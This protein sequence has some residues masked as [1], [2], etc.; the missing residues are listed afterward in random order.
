M[1]TET[2]HKELLRDML[3]RAIHEGDVELATAALEAGEKASGKRFFD[4]DRSNAFMALAIKCNQPEIIRLLRDRGGFKVDF[5]EHIVLIVRENKIDLLSVCLEK[6]LDVISAIDKDPWGCQFTELENIEAFKVA[7]AKSKNPLLFLNQCNQNWDSPI[8]IAAKNNSFEFFSKMIE[9]GAIPNHR[10]A[11]STINHREE[12]SAQAGSQT[13]LEA[14][15][16]SGYN[17]NEKMRGGFSLLHL[18]AE[19]GCTRLCEILIDH[20][21]N[22]EARCA[23][24]ATPILWGAQWPK[25]ASLLIDKGANL[26]ATTDKG[27]NILFMCIE[28]GAN[29]CR[30]AEICEIVG[31]DSPLFEAKDNFKNTLLHIIPSL[32]NENP[33][34]FSRLLDRLIPSQIN[35]CN[36]FGNTPLVSSFESTSFRALEIFLSRGADIERT[37]SA[38]M[39]PLIIAAKE[40]N[41][42]ACKI[43][44]TA[45]ANKDAQDIGGRT[46]MDWAIDGHHVQIFSV[47]ASFSAKTNETDLRFI[48]ENVKT[49][50]FIKDT[51]LVSAMRTEDIEFLKAHLQRNP[52]QSAADIKSGHSHLNR[53][54]MKQEMKAFFNSWIAQKSIN[55]ILKNANTMDPRGMNKGP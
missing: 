4:Y 38:G 2:K 45:G 16:R 52:D 27:S 8:T 41:V 46:A 12:L 13:K 49:H 51:P 34:K 24:G 48:P 15:I 3:N 50:I 18:A 6:G 5:F 28:K 29:L 10:T 44:L 47:L 23:T 7:M 32:I 30:F 40:G 14:L 42:D 1:K 9:L 26:E 39:T 31:K 35:E 43:L 20:G 19:K 55:D 21:A 25:V 53:S 17:V 22:L 36:E 37:N 54:S 33:Q 11:R